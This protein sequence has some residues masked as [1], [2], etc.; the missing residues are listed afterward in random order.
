MYQLTPICGIDGGFNEKLPLIEKCGKLMCG[1]DQLKFIMD[2]MRLMALDTTFLHPSQML[3][4]LLL[5]LPRILDIVDPAPLSPL[6]IVDLIPLI[7]LLTVDL[8]PLQTLLKDDLILP[9]ALLI[10]ERALDMPFEIVVLTVF[11]VFVTVFL[12]IFQLLEKRSLIVLSTVD[13]TD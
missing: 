6:E 3:L 12:I 7:A 11:I 2:L 10:V 4:N 1:N 13:I 5:M 8:M 9:S